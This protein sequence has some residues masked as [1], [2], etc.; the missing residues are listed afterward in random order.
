M[1]MGSSGT[2]GA[3]LGVQE[4]EIYG[5]YHDYTVGDSYDTCFASVYKSQSSGAASAG[6]NSWGSL[7]KSLTAYDYGSSNGRG[8]N[9]EAACDYDSGSH[10]IATCIPKGTMLRFYD[11]PFVL[12]ITANL[13]NS[14]NESDG[15]VTFGGNITYITVAV[16][17]NPGDLVISYDGVNE[18]VTWD[19]TLISRGD[20]FRY[21]MNATS[22]GEFKGGQFNPLTIRVTSGK[23]LFLKTLQPSSY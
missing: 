5:T 9:I 21:T 17:T 12:T 11:T 14:R 6:S 15:D 22:G 1:V 20:N 19:G 4:D 3:G 23:V 7:S 18:D 10:G 8:F 2:I 16:G 13:I